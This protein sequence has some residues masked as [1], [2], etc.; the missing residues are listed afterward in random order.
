MKQVFLDL[1]KEC[2]K[3]YE[4]KDPDKL[5]ECLDDAVKFK[6]RDGQG[7]L[8]TLT[9]QDL[10][11]NNCKF[12]TVGNFKYRS[13]V[14][15]GVKG[16]KERR[17]QGHIQELLDREA[18]FMLGLVS[19][20]KDTLVEE[21][22]MTEDEANQLVSKKF[23]D[24]YDEWLEKAC[25][26]EIALNQLSS[27][28]GYGEIPVH[29]I[30]LEKAI[31]DTQEAQK[32]GRDFVVKAIWRT[33]KARMDVK[34]HDSFKNVMPENNP[35]FEGKCDSGY[36]T[37]NPF[38][39]ERLFDR[40]TSDHGTHADGTANWSHD[41]Y[42]IEDI[43]EQEGYLGYYDNNGYGHGFLG[44]DYYDEIDW[45]QLSEVHSIELFE[46]VDDLKDVESVYVGRIHTDR[47]DF[48][49]FD[50]KKTSWTKII[51]EVY[52]KVVE[53]FQDKY[54]EA[55]IPATKFPMERAVEELGNLI[56]W[57]N[58]N[59]PDKLEKLTEE[60]EALPKEELERRLRIQELK[61]KGLIKP[62]NG[63]FAELKA[64]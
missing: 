54:H 16:S 40:E 59:P 29:Q 58:E 38:T 57:A 24:R 34:Y 49:F 7:N 35:S 6:L 48:R 11:L 33:M 28:L 17:L 53:E 20:L 45:N 13:H 8:I 5:I 1:T 9:E 62:L 4:A 23:Y 22:E 60:Y 42:P 64:D 41:Y 27:D 32:L 52:A 3:K 2:Q 30:N 25:C 14:L 55:L 44:E 51:G 43:S 18:N 36:D 46:L 21:K 61:D 12:D 37:L 39:E 15:S 26:V 19:Q 10:C 56:D 31:M 50:P 47:S 63:Y